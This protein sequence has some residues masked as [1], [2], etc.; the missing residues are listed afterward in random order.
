MANGSNGQIQVEVA[1]VSGQKLF[2]FGDV[3]SNGTVGSLLS[4]AVMEMNMPQTDVAGQ[5]LVYHARLEREGR[6]LRT[7]ERIGDAVLPDDRVT[8]FP[9]IDAG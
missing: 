9:N 1:D 5:P 3:D 2:R 7:A 8:I 6:H 4:R